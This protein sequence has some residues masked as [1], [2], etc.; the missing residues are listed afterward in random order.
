M[1]VIGY[2][3]ILTVV[4]QLNEKYLKSSAVSD[5]DPSKHVPSAKFGFT[6]SSHLQERLTER[7]SI[8]TDMD[9]AAFALGGLL[10][11]PVWV[12]IDLRK[13]EAR[14]YD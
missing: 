14:G 5:P 13:P 12:S 7:L 8:P 6:L 2:L 10:V 3:N 9:C 4:E 1:P 11:P